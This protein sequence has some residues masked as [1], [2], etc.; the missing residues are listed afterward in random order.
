MSTNHF[1]IQVEH[2]SKRYGLGAKQQAYKTLRE[3]ITNTLIYPIRQ[4]RHRSVETGSGVET[5]WALNDVS[6][7]VK[8]GEALGIIGRNGAGKSTLLKVL[9]SITEPTKGRISL[10][11]RVGALL[12]VGTGFHPEL[13][14]RENVYLN[15]AILG[16]TRAEIVV[17]FDEIVDFAEIERFIDTPVKHYSSG[18][19]LRLG[20]AVAAHLEP[21]I[22]IVDEVLAVGDASFQRKC[23]GKMTEVAGKGRTVLFVS[24]NMAVIHKLCTRTIWLQ[25]G[26]VIG[27]GDT[28]DIIRQYLDSNTDSESSGE[29]IYTAATAPQGEGVSL[30]SIRTLNAKHEQQSS[31]HMD[32]GLTLEL[33]VNVKLEIENLHFSVE[34]Y[35]YEGIHAFTTTT[36]DTFDLDHVTRWIPG[37]YRI[38]CRV[39]GDLLNR[40]S[41]FVSLNAQI[42]NVRYLFKADNIL[43]FSIT[44]FGGAGGAKSAKRP[45]IFRPRL[46]WEIVPAETGLLLQR[47]D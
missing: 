11:G 47:G 19:A 34:F 40:G 12:E 33:N 4:F 20:F 39:A 22:L 24:H 27:D 35:T 36:W 30:M 46:Q 45:G 41:Y 14:G 1:A 25:A 26:K 15:G 28:P 37:E 29:T 31:Y 3:S 8:Q 32:E 5:F 18:M 44:E 42:P 23:M 6:F 16:M 13:T 17:K 43:Q 38:T 21:E 2:L 10:N 9:S 7:E